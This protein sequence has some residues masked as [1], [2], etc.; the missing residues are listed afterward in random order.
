MRGKT[1]V[2]GVV[3]ILG[4]LVGCSTGPTKGVT[5][6]VGSI[7]TILDVDPRDGWVALKSPLSTEIMNVGSL[8]EIQNGDPAFLGFIYEDPACIPKS[9]WK[10]IPPAKAPNFNRNRKIDYG[11]NLGDSL[12]I[13][14]SEFLG[15]SVGNE[16]DDPEFSTTVD[17]KKVTVE[18]VNT[19]LVTRYLRDN[20]SSLDSLCKEEFNS[21]S[22]FI[23]STIYI[24]NDGTISFNDVNGVKIDLNDPT[25]LD[26]KKKFASFGLSVDDSGSVTF[27]DKNIVVA[28]KAADFSQGLKAAGVEPV[29]NP[30]D[31][32]E[33]LIKANDAL[34][35]S[36]N[37]SRTVLY[38]LVGVVGVATLVALT[39]QK[40]PP[41]ATARAVTFNLRPPTLSSGE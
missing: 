28:I 6:R 7:L 41:K 26:E 4:F 5:E 31:V 30:V 36:D 23:I 20:Y 12:G 34:T 9:E 38:G 16:G 27:Q 10:I 13:D 1:S 2:V 17:L 39:N 18:T 40:D 32:R 33:K 24:V 25:K 37:T 21:T 3:T 19:R 22:R 15:I 29:A 35:T 14:G 11:F 8:L